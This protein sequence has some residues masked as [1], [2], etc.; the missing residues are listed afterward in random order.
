[1][2]PWLVLMAA[3]GGT[4]ATYWGVEQDEMPLLVRLAAGAALGLTLFGLVGLLVALFLGLGAAA[5]AGATLVVVAPLAA[6]AKARVRTRLAC[7]LHTVP[8][9]LRRH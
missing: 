4:L 6:L 1:M 5:L 3:A 7:D 9:A 8:Q 2:A